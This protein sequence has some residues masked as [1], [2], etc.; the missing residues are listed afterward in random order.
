MGIGK[1][2]AGHIEFVIS[3][4]LF[5][6]VVGFVIL[7]FKPLNNPS[8][9]QES[10]SQISGSVINNITISLG[11]YGVKINTNEL[12][13]AVDIGDI[14]DNRGV[15][16]LSPE[17]DILPSAR[18]GSMVYF[19]WKKQYGY[20][21]IHAG[22][23]ISTSG[24]SGSYP[25]HDDKLYIIGSVQKRKLL[26]EKEIIRLKQ[27]YENDYVRLKKMLNIPDGVDFAFEVSF[28]SEKINVERSAP[29]SA[30]VFGEQK[31]KEILRKDGSMSFA[32]VT[33]K[34]W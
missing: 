26:S 28:G 6:G 11:T 12:K 1:K 9:M 24:F 17:G 19:D 13:I 18:Q 15:F 5:A 8:I 27:D 20:V 16:V 4:V 31:R 34:I 22:E 33:V 32:D 30:E 7:F 29:I 21:Y 23:S 10:L 2:G 25:A 14:D 3:F